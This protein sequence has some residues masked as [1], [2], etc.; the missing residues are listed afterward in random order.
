MKGLR[1][2]I[3][4]AFSGKYP[5]DLNV[6]MHMSNKVYNLL[7]DIRQSLRLESNPIV[8]IWAETSVF[9]RAEEESDETE[10]VAGVFITFFFIHYLQASK[11]K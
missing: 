7:F 2:N 5:I 4:I 10:C 11:C 6:R 9:R 1:L 3:H 8:V